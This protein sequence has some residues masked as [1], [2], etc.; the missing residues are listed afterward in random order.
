MQNSAKLTVP[1][2]PSVACSTA[3]AIE[4][5]SVWSNNLDPSGRA[6]LGVHTL[7]Y[8]PPPV[9]AAIGGVLPKIV[10]NKQ[11]MV[12]VCALGLAIRT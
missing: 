12:E 3:K 7:A 1:G 5:D 2:G 9:P 8:D 10:N 4:W 6:A 11:N